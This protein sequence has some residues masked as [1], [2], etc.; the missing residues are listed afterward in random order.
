MTNDKLNVNKGSTRLVWNI[1]EKF[2]KLFEEL[3]I[4]FGNELIQ[5]QMITFLS[6]EWF[7]VFQ[8]DRLLQ[9]LDLYGTFF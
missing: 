8:V 5:T 9:Y 4:L 2:S 7:L 3:L 6:L 1:D